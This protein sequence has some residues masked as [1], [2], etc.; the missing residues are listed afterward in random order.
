MLGKRG[1]KWPVN[2]TDC[3]ANKRIGNPDGIGRGFTAAKT[4]LR[5]R[6]LFGHDVNMVIRDLQKTTFH[7]ELV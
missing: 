7:V 2:F 6:G 4:A 1:T 3:R 5:C